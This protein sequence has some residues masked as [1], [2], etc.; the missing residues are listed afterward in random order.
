M[1]KTTS[2]QG[3]SIKCNK[4]LCKSVVLLGKSS[5]LALD[6]IVKLERHC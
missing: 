6:F 1:A 3:T 2:K 4:I 5:A